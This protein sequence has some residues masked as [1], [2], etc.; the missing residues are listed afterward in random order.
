MTGPLHS[1]ASIPAG[2]TED[3]RRARLHH[4]HT[5]DETVSLLSGWAAMRPELIDCIPSASR[6]RA[7]ASGRSPSPT[8]SRRS[9]RSAGLLHRRR[10]ARRRNQR[11]RGDALLHQPGPDAATA[12][13]ANHP[14]GGHQDHLRRPMNNPD[15]LSLYHLTAQTLRSTVRPTTPTAMA[16]STRTPARI[17]T[18][19][20][21]SVRC[22]VR[23]QG[24]RESSRT[25][26]IRRVARCG[27][28]VT[29]KET[30]SSTRRASTATGRPLQRGRH[31]RPRLHRN[32][33]ENW[34]PMREETGRGQTQAGA[35]DDPLS[36]PERARSSVPDAHPNVAIVESLDTA[37][38]MPA[39][40]STSRSDETI[41][42]PTSS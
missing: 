28:S 6:S 25:R 17:S 41:S 37:V 31:R 1:R 2:E 26:K 22:A 18:A 13:T 32:Y 11:H 8:R 4:Y 34:R 30:T 33:P 40:A 7:R 36:E 16:C 10:P 35:G 15:G 24:Q 19:T 21:S 23:R 29:T 39:R 20:A 5:Y 9:P 12:A 42:R 27:G 38:P 14:A 3:R